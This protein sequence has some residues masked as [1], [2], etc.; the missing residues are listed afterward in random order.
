MGHTVL[1]AQNIQDTLDFWCSIGGMALSDI[2][3]LALT[4]DLTVQLYFMHCD[5]ARQHSFALAQ[6][7][8][9]SPGCV[10]IMVEYGRLDEVGLALDRVMK[11]KVP[12]AITLGQHVNDEMVSFYAMTPG[13]FIFELGW[14][15]PP[16]E[17]G[18]EVVFETTSG[19][20]WGH[21]WVL[22]DTNYKP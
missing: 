19:S 11:H 22:N 15:G 13:N 6:M 9:E 12:I 3:S 14:G 1:P 8:T 5:N 16:K 7:P 2:L 21:K 18:Q 20:H 10:H 17:W 4:P